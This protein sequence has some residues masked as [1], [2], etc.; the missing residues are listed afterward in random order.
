MKLGVDKISLDCGIT[1]DKKVKKINWD[2]AEGYNKSLNL[3]NDHSG[4]ILTDRQ[5]SF[6]NRKL[7]QLVPIILNQS[8]LLLNIK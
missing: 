7:I 5:R 1:A 8:K 3:I 2:G 6:S 4:Q